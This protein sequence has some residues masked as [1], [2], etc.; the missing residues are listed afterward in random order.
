M[1]YLIFLCGNNKAIFY[2]IMV[3][4]K[5]YNYHLQ[6]TAMAHKLLKHY[7]LNFMFIVI[8]KIIL[9]KHHSTDTIV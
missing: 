3:F 2:P 1:K 6:M 5:K 4:S 9:T 7:H 8:F